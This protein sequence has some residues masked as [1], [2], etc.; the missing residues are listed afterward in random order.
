MLDGLSGL[1][2]GIVLIVS[3]LLVTIIFLF[4]SGN[5]FMTIVEQP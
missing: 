4:K 2:F 5:F 3:S 1:L